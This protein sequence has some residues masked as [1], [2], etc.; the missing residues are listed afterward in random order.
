MPKLLDPDVHD[1][2]V[3]FLSHL[4]Q[5][6]AS[7]LMHVV[8]DAVGEEGLQL[9]GRGLAD[10]T[11]L[12]SSPARIWRDICATNSDHIGEALDLLIADLKALRADLTTGDALERIFES[13]TDW[14]AKI[15]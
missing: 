3:A 11:R 9:S 1:R 4:P 10:T 6:S 13:A 8:G 5:L 7:A 12:A 2:L 15:P 14:K